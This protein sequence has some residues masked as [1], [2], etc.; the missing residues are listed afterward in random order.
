M[1]QNDLIACSI[2]LHPD[3]PNPFNYSFFFVKNKLV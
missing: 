1:R 2:E 3:V